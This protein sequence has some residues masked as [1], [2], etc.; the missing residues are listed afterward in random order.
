MAGTGDGAVTAAAVPA[1]AAGAVEGAALAAAPSVCG[2][3]TADLAA[4]CGAGLAIV[5]S[6]AEVG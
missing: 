2:V 3:F 4:G 1:V 6:P 5:L